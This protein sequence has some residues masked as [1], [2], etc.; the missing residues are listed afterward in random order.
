MS[1][2]IQK[3][4]ALPVERMA[5]IA[6]V[7]EA[8]AASG[9]FGAK[10]AASGLIIAATCHQQ[11]MTL[12]DFQRTF[13]IIDGKP[14]MK[15]DAML[16]KFRQAGGR[17]KIIENSE[18]RAAAEFEFEG[19]PPRLMEYTMDDARRTGDCYEGKSTTVK[20]S[21]QKRPDDMLW[22]RLVSRSV[23]RLAPEIVSGLYTPEEVEDFGPVRGEPVAKED[24]DTR[25]ANAKQAEPVDDVDYNVCPIGEGFVGKRWDEI[26]DEILEAALE[27]ENDAI[28]ERHREIIFDVL[29][30]RRNN[31]KGEENVYK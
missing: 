6:A 16:A 20:Y 4:T 3:Y 18:T 12:L 30:A 13:H 1:T 10:N 15:A 19:N 22:A 8:I 7:G 11:G 27:S 17:Y 5:D 2:E 9:M 26:E 23:R 14:S 25:I 28:T 29:V 24:V 31:K 21:W